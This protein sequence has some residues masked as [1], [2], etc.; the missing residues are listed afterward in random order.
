MFSD[1]HDL[2][3]GQSAEGD[4]ILKRDHGVLFLDEFLLARAE[5]RTMS[6]ISATAGLSGGTSLRGTRSGV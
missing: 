4:A 2:L 6:L 3:L 1:G 5:A